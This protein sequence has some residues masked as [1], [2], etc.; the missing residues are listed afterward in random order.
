[1]NSLFWNWKKINV[2][3]VE[4]IISTNNAQQMHGKQRN[5]CKKINHFGATMCKATDRINR[6]VHTM[7]EFTADESEIEENIRHEEVI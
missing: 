3:D 1:M 4:E 7:E 2:T 5:N 6:M